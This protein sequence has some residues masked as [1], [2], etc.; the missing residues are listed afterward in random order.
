VGFQE[1]L[2]GNPFKY[3]IVAGADSH[4][5]FSDN[6]EFNYTGVHG[7]TDKTPKIRLGSTGSVAGEA[8]RFFSTP[9]T[10]GV[11]APENTR[12]EIFDAIKRKDTYATSGTFIR[13]RFFGGW[14]YVL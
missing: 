5:A 3:G 11:W 14:D 4:D 12:T 10:T 13:L 8:A 2:G 1:M 7:N 6:E 9:T